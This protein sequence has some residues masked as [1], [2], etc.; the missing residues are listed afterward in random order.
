LAD[1][2][3]Y[4]DKMKELQSICT[5]VMPKLHGGTSSNNNKNSHNSTGGPTVEEVD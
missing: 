2:E 1:K 5:P 4:D 3:E